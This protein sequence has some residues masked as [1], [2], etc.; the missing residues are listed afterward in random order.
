V[1]EERVVFTGDTIFCECQTWLYVSDVDQWLASLDRIGSL[2]VDLILPGHGPV[3]T[4]HYLAV[5]RSVL[6]DWVAAVAAAI[7]KGWNREE[8]IA[9][10]SFADRFPVDIGQEYMMDHIQRSNAGALYDKLTG[11]R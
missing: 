11:A 9:R 5:Q 7:A 2:D 4:K 10:V 1:P 6:L 8:T 3:T